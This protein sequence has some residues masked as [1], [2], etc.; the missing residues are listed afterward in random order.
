MKIRKKITS[1]F[2]SLMLLLSLTVR[3]SAAEGSQ[4]MAVHFI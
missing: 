4:I 3:V 1:L 2:L